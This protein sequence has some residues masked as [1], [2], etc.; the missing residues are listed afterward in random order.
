MTRL[1]I[2]A[3]GRAQAPLHVPLLDLTA[4]AGY[5]FVMVS[6]ECAV[7]LVS[8]SAYYALLLWGGLCT[9]VFL[10][11]T[12][13]RILYAEARS[14]YGVDP[15]RHNY[16][17]LAL[18]LLQLPFAFFLGYLPDRGSIAAAPA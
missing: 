18:A 14:N 16:L 1:R 3:R 15:Q 13:K 4:Y 11:K 2:T 8:H 6:A 5:T 17:L 12:M 10:V 9:A 7:G